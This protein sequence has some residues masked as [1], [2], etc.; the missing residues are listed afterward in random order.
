MTHG[1]NGLQL[2]RAMQF[3]WSCRLYETGQ[4]RQNSIETPRYREPSGRPPRHRR[5]WILNI[6]PKTEQVSLQA[7]APWLM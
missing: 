2:Q 6:N 4:L 3:A 7:Q 5:I 1:M